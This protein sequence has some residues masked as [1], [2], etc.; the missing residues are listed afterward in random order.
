VTASVSSR[1]LLVLFS[2]SFLFVG[3]SPAPD[4]LRTAHLRRVQGTGVTI[5]LSFSFV[6]VAFRHISLRDDA[7]DLSRDLN[8]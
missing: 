8:K 1:S 7:F 4:D 3:G 5:F 2:F 6:C